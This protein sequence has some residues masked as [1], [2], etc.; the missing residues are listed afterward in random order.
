VILNPHNFARYYGSPVGSSQVPNAVFADFWSKL[1]SKYASNANVLFNLVNEPNTMPTE[2]W[3]SAANAAIAAIRKAGAHNT[4]VAPGTAWTGGASWYSSGYGTPNAVAMLAIDDPDDN[5]WFEAHQYLDSD[6]S[7]GSGT[8]VSKT[9]GSERLAPFVKWLRDNKKKGFLGEFAGADNA[10]CNAAIT[11]MLSYVMSAS[12]VLMGWT[13]WAGGP[14]WGNY[15]FT[16]EP[17]SSGAERPQWS[18]L[19][20]FLSET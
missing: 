17:T 14:W 2:Q 13:W 4:I 15:Q 6:A 10:T 9:A 1:S 20:P 8:C 5:V 18:L 16:L 3:V 19:A 12:D 11:D 7:G